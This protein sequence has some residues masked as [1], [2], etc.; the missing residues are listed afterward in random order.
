MPVTKARISCVFNL[1]D[2]VHSISLSRTR[3]ESNLRHEGW[4]DK[5]C[6]GVYVTVLLKTMIY[7]L[8]NFITLIRISPT[9]FLNKCGFI[10]T[11]STVQGE[12]GRNI[13]QMS[14]KKFDTK[15]TVA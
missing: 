2:S 9:L 10:N 4:H 11:N 13:F 1:K 5:L 15:G 14:A 6:Q 8:L 12:G 3:R 7:V